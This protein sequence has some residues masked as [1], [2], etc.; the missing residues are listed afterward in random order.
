MEAAVGKGKRKRGKEKE[1]LMAIQHLDGEKWGQSVF[2]LIG[3]GGL[4]EQPGL[5]DEPMRRK[6]SYN[7]EET[8][9]LGQGTGSPNG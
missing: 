1:S 6:N 8:S 7:L 2:D 4:V 9:S 3:N 5:F